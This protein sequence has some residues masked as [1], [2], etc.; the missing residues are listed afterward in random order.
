MGLHE[1]PRE[2]LSWGAKN[3]SRA[4]FFVFWRTHL[5]DRYLSYFPVKKFEEKALCDTYT[6]PTAEILSGKNARALVS[7]V[8][9]LKQAWKAFQPERARQVLISP[10]CFLKNCYFNWDLVF[11]QLKSGIISI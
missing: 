5:V 4:T 10:A 11:K 2:S 3:Y 1:L 8:L 9:Y 6:L 7:M